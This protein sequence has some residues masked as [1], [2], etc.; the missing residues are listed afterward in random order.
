MLS[1]LLLFS[2][3]DP[4]QIKENYQSH[5]FFLASD[6]MMGRETGEPGQKIA[7]DYISRHLANLGLEPAFPSQP[8]PW[9][10]EFE[11]RATRVDLENSNATVRGRG[12]TLHLKIGRDFSGDTFQGQ[13]FSG[14]G[15]MVFAG[16]GLDI[17]GYRDFDKLNVSNHWV[18]ILENRPHTKGAIFG[19][20]EIEHTSRFSKVMNAWERSA[21]GVIFLSSGGEGR[22][23]NADM[24]LAES[25]P[26]EPEK[27]GFPVIRIDEDQV[28]AF[29]GKYYNRFLKSRES[30]ETLEQPAGFEM[31]GR[32]LDL[33]LLKKTEFIGSENVIGIIPGSDP[34]LADEFVVFSA[35]YDHVGIR[36]G[37]VYNGADDNASGTVT[38]LLLAEQLSRTHPRRTAIFLF[39]SGEEHGLLGSEHFIAHPVKPLEQIV[40]NVNFDMV[41]RNTNGALGIIPA[42]NED[43]STINDLIKSINQE[44]GFNIPF[45][46]DMD[47]FHRR[48]DHYNFVEK[49]IPAVFF[50][51]TLHEDYHKPTDDPHLLEYDFM[52][53]NFPLYE[54][55]AMRLLNDPEK[56]H[57]HRQETVEDTENKST[58]PNPL[59][60]HP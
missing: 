55:L 7:A 25:E 24:E 17:E 56:P 45:R 5:V 12:E 30:I 20:E 26:S 42:K 3:L 16:Y 15:T 48:S 54:E 14:S 51:G 33:Q 6:H 23:M 28:P 32:N 53:R 52:V 19:Q 36:N 41:G 18:V 38:I 21:L 46:E 58:L 35:H 43:T 1:L 29:M 40:A 31:K 60:D 13:G 50:M 37:V 57:F 11:L 34:K 27:S 44:K 2:C 49:G 9:L 39:A 10:Q 22:G 47:G 4:S 8:S 59:K